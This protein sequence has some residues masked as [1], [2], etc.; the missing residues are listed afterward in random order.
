MI[1]DTTESRHQH[2]TQPS[3][4]TEDWVL[5]GIQHLT[6]TL[7]GMPTFNINIWMSALHSLQN[8]INAWSGVHAPAPKAFRPEY[9]PAQPAPTAPTHDLLPS[10]LER[11]KWMEL[12]LATHPA[13]RVPVNATQPTIPTPKAHPTPSAQPI[14]SQTRSKI[15]Q[16]SQQPMVEPVTHRIR[17]ATTHSNSPSH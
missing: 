13:P 5:H 2:L 9:D 14:T 16:P 6:A 8:T 17:S 11:D 3:V 4:T 10:A 1:L 12:L 15:S 7:K